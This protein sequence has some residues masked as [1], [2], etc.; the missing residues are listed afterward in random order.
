MKNPN[1]NNDDRP[2]IYI[3]LYSEINENKG[4]EIN[5]FLFIKDKNERDNADNHILKNNLWNYFKKINYDHIEDYIKIKNEKGEEIG[6]IFRCCPIEYIETYKDKMEQKKK[7]ENNFYGN[8]ANRR[9]CDNFF[10]KKEKNLQSNII[11]PKDSYSRKIVQNI[12]SN[13]NKNSKLSNID[14]NYN[15]NMPKINVNMMNNNNFNNQNLNNQIS[16]L[17]NENSNLKNEINN[18][19][20]TIKLKEEENKELKSRI[21]ILINKSENKP[22]LVDFDKIKIIQFISMDHS[23][24]C[25]IKCL[26]TDIF[27]EVEEKLFKIYP[28]YRETNNSFQVNGRN[29][30]RFKTIEENNIPDGIGVQITRIY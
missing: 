14:N 29:I 26:F 11:S 5:F 6:Y 24:I 23:V 9:S 4:N 28:E 7:P 17:K 3:V 15:Q 19:K 18:L 21:D 27:A 30:L 8:S 10:R 12:F 1:D 22:K 2:Y 13:P 16:E 25:P 20:K